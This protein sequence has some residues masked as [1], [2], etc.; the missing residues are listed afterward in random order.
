MVLLLWRMPFNDEQF[1][2]LVVRVG[3]FYI[4]RNK[5]RKAQDNMETV[6]ENGSVPNDSQRKAYLQTV[7]HYF[8]EFEREARSQ[9]KSVDKRLENVSQVHFNLTAERGVAVRRI[10]ATQDVLTQLTSLDASP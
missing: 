9:L 7:R 6:L 5:M 4:T 8:S 1:R 3:A 2:E 10:E